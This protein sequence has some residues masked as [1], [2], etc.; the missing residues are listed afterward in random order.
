VTTRLRA[1]IDKVSLCR[2]PAYQ[3]AQVLAVRTE[4]VA[5]PAAAPLP[6]DLAD[7]LEALGVELLT[8]VAT[9]SRPW[10]GSPARFT[11]EQYLRACLIVRS[12]DAPAKE[13]GSL[14]VL[15][16]GGIQDCG[17]A[18]NCVQVC[19][20]E[21]PLTTSIASMNRDVTRLVVKDLFFKDEE[22]EA[23]VGGPA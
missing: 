23:A 15:E 4:P 14:P 16:P 3:E 13:R 21:I 5:L 7:R 19:P 1:H 20:K 10:D 18:Q 2:F 17:K 22:S 9:T 6:A 11:D 8:R 12:G